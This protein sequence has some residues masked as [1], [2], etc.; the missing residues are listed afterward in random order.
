MLHFISPSYPYC[1]RLRTGPRAWS[2]SPVLFSS[3]SKLYIKVYNH[4]QTSSVARAFS[5]PF[6]L[7]SYA[8]VHKRPCISSN[9]VPSRLHRKIYDQCVIC[10]QLHYEPSS[11][12][13]PGAIHDPRHRT[14][15][16]TSTK[17]HR[18]VI[19]LTLSL[20]N[21]IMYHERIGDLWSAGSVFYPA[22]LC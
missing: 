8:V 9:P 19:A 21:W 17:L 12:S 11:R 13:H 16:H 14:Q 4:H 7:N 6:A 3:Q 15:S 2:N 20:V 18:R 5:T 1:I 22:C 10:R